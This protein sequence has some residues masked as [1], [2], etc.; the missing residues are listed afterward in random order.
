MDAVGHQ[1]TIEFRSRRRRRGIPLATR[2]AR[3]RLALA[4]GGA[5]ALLAIA[6]AGVE[7]GTSSSGSTRVYTALVTGRGTAALT[8]TGS[9][10][11]LEVHHFSPPP[12]G[13][14]Y[15]VWLGRRGHPPSPT[16]ALFSVTAA[17][18][19][20]VEVPGSLRGVNLVMVTP[21]PAG[22][23]RVPTH[24]AVIRARLS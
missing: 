15:E 13:Q 16:S 18:S 23:S 7:L 10:A 22:G 2:L 1:P 17:G 12:A 9:H 4:L 14:I 3:P 11:A 5:L 20:D 21:E 8:I 6:I 24:P 19:A